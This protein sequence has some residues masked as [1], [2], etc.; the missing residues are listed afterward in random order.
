M[1]SDACLYRLTE[2]RRLAGERMALEKNF[3]Y[4]VA[5][6]GGRPYCSL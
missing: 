6:G 2:G 5:E 1:Y 4:S 3:A